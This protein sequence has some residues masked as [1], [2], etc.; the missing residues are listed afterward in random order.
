MVKKKENLD[1]EDLWVKITKTVSPIQSDKISPINFRIDDKNI[2][3]QKRKN[4]KESKTISKK[5]K[6]LQHNKFARVPRNKPSD[7]RNNEAFGIDA[8][9]S[10]K[11]RTGKFD[12]DATLDL[13]GLTKEGAFVKLQNFVKKSFFKKHR[14]ILIITGKGTGGKGVLRN[15]LP[16]WL[17]SDICAPYIL[18][19]DQALAK[20]G[21]KGAFYIRLRRDRQRCQ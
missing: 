4:E 8:I 18:A 20:D 13:H 17:K 2:I 21:G 14:T 11:L 1:N 9:S 12:I 5:S 19:F 6:V 7:L 16:I 15:Q 3:G 10:K